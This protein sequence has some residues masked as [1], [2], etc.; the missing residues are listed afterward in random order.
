MKRTDGGETVWWPPRVADLHARLAACPEATLTAEA[1]R[2]TRPVHLTRHWLATTPAVEAWHCVSDTTLGPALTHTRLVV[3]PPVD[4]RRAARMDVLDS[5]AFLGDLADDAQARAVTATLS[6]ALFG[7]PWGG[8]AGVVHA[9]AWSPGLAEAWRRVVPGV[10]AGPRALI[11]PLTAVG[12][13]SALSNVPEAA[14]GLPE[15][16]GARARGAFLAIQALARRTALRLNARVVFQGASRLAWAL[17]ELLASA[18]YDVRPPWTPPPSDEPAPPPLNPEARDTDVL[19]VAQPWG[20]HAG[21]GAV[22]PRL[23]VELAVGGVAAGLDAE[24]REQAVPVL[25]DFLVRGG[26][27]VVA[28]MEAGGGWPPPDAEGVRNTL[29]AAVDHVVRAIWDEATRGGRSAREAALVV[30]LRRLGAARQAL[31]GR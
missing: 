20:L 1:R 31:A 11:G 14:G 22:R 16:D 30:A 15:R 3:P 25:P 26:E 27:G 23:I 4:D 10:L 7:L 24:L 12:P 13:R 21:S 29:A 2:L 8:A 28:A 6:G 19:V 9:A 18:G 5:T 17:A